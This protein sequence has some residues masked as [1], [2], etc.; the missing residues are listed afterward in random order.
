MAKAKIRTGDKV[1][2]IAGKDKGLTGEVIR[3][4]P[5]GDRVLVQG[6]NSVKRHTKAGQEKDNQQGGIVTKEAPVH[7]SNVMVL[8]SDDKATR[9]KKRRDE[10]DKK[11]SDGSSYKSTR[12]VRVAVRNDK[13]IS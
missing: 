11:R 13:E 12:G 9:L 6:V 2:I 8:D 7:I 4:Y 1:Q 10:V 5:A 3:T